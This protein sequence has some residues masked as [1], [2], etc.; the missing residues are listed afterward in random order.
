MV[1]F[2]GCQAG[3]PMLACL[4]QVGE[5]AY[6]PVK[7]TCPCNFTLY[8]EVAARGNIVLSGQQPAHITQ[9]RSKRAALEKPIRLMHLSETGE[10]IP[11][12]EVPVLPSEPL[13]LGW[14]SQQGMVSRM[15]PGGEPASGRR[16][17]TPGKAGLGPGG[18]AVTS[19]WRQLLLRPPWAGPLS[20]SIL[21]HAAFCQPPSAFAQT[22]SPLRSPSPCFP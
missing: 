7:S 4:P 16:A 5:D 13:R 15:H 8:Y 2:C 17:H 3:P 22:D 9:Q 20:R 10:L 6:F 18:W 11:R 19:C 21:C 12:L 1:L 14:A